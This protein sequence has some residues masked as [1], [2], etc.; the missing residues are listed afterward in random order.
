MALPLKLRFRIPST[1]MPR[2][3]SGEA[4]LGMRSKLRRGRVAVVAGVLLF[5]A[6]Q[7]SLNLGIRTGLLPD[8][9][10][11]F[12]E[13][14]DLLREHP[15][16]TDATPIRVLALGSSRTQLAFDAGRFAATVRSA[17]GRPAEAFNFGTP[18]AGPMVCALYLRRLLAAGLT[19]DH[20]VLEIH[21]GFITEYE[22]TFEGRWLHA[23]RL[24]PEEMTTVRGF[25]WGIPDPPHHGW[26]GW[27]ASSYAYRFSLLNRY[28][29]KW[30]P[31]PYGLMVG[32]AH[33]PHGW[34]KG[35]TIPRSE[36]P[37]LLRRAWDQYAVT[38][39]GYH[40]GG[41][42]VAA[43]QDVLA[44]CHDRG[45]PVTV[46]L[47]PESSD[48]RA[49][50]GAA[51][52]DCI[53]VFAR[54]LAGPK[55]AVLDAREWL[56]DELFTDGHHMPPTGAAVYTDRLATEWLAAHAISGGSPR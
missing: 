25:G 44:R 35:P 46:V 28:A 41:P 26:Q 55:V 21:P 4:K 30:L 45:I 53:S 32:G 1:R 43:V 48:Y 12:A 40:V 18:A 23:Y 20:V 6:G 34:Q 11:V 42:G 36:Y 16:F 49:W 47:M 8:P 50:Y 3:P 24:R 51:G 56:A 10:P 37:K 15:V 2:S 31:T 54:G 7:A 17:T 22:P 29:P 52:Y 5:M 14:F 27:A 38:F 19:P 33:D 9:D 39:D 13:K